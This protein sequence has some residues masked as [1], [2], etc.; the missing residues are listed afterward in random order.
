MGLTWSSWSRGI[1][2]HG[3]LCGVLMVGMTY[4]AR[5]WDLPVPLI[6]M[7]LFMPYFVLSGF[8]AARRHGV[9]AGMAAGAATAVT[10]DV[11]VFGGAA[12]YAAATPSQP[13]TTALLWVAVDVLVGGFMALV[14]V[15]CGR[16][17]AAL[18]TLGRSTPS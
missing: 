5:G 17:G 4:W 9:D 3:V 18:A 14:G 11:I 7:F 15:F 1:Y 2:P 16:L 6:A 8:L 10:G 13:W 12:I